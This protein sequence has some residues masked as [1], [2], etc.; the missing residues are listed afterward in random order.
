MNIIV[1]GGNHQNTLS[2]IRAL[3]EKYRINVIVVDCKESECYIIRSKYI[4]HWDIVK[5]DSDIIGVLFSKYKNKRSIVITCSDGT[6]S[7]IDINYNSLSPYFDVFNCR[8]QGRLTYFLEKQNQV[9]CAASVGLKVPFSYEFVVGDPIPDSID[10]PCISKPL[11]SVQMEKRFEI[12]KNKIQLEDIINTYPIGGR[13]LLQKYIKKDYEIVVDG[14]STYGNI[15]IPGFVKKLRDN[16]GNTSY[17]VTKSIDE[18]P[19]VIVDQ[20]RKLVS[21]IGYQGLF[22][23]EFIISNNDYYFVEINLRNDATT[24]SLCSAG[25]NLPCNYVD[26]RLSIFVSGNEKCQSGVYSIV[27]LVDP[28]NARK[29]N[30]SLFKW[31]SD[32]K[33]AKCY[34]FY[35]KNDKKPFYCALRNTILTKTIKKII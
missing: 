5:K 23:V 12:A 28:F 16:L 33:R 1:I 25:V 34:Y 6:A 18:L 13:I 2:I 21:K 4:D 35:N 22:G 9:D 19:E 15:W 3:G 29:Q 8:E 17:S 32:L 24:Y 30:V 26:S 20:I 27:E 10:Y 14:I 11:S 7:I 31:I